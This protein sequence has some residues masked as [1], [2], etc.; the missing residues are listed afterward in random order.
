MVSKLAWHGIA[1]R[2]V[3][4]GPGNK[5]CYLVVTI[6]TRTHP[7]HDGRSVRIRLSESDRLRLLSS[8]VDVITSGKEC[9][10]A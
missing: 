8:L 1:P 6:E 4:P 9:G 10:R 7:Q 5:D 2:I 3:P